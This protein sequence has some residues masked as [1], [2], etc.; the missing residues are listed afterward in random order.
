MEILLWRLETI[1]ISWISVVYQEDP[2]QAMLATKKEIQ[3][4]K[5][6]IQRDQR[7][8]KEVCDS[9]GCVAEKATPEEP[10]SH[11]CCFKRCKLLRKNL[12]ETLKK[13]FKLR[14][15]LYW[16]LIHIKHDVSFKTNQ[17]EIM[18]YKKKKKKRGKRKTK[19]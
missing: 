10:E 13:A 12:V 19:Y 7:L 1:S 8:A 14:F 15:K 4:C 11:F 6:L 17:S 3:E 18:Q 16:C 9:T 2:H 5:D